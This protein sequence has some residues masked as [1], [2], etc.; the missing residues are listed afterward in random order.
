[1]DVVCIL[2]VYWEKSFEKMKL[3]RSTKL[4]SNH[5]NSLSEESVVSDRVFDGTI[6]EI[7]KINTAIL[8]PSS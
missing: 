7:E 8:I 1:M 4:N 3:P 2:V 5:R 6:L